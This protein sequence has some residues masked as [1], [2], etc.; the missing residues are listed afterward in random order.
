MLFSH[1]LFPVCDWILQLHH[2]VPVFVV[3]VLFQHHEVFLT[4]SSLH[5]RYK[6]RLDFVLKRL[7]DLLDQLAL[8]VEELDAEPDIGDVVL[9]S[10]HEVEAV[11]L[12]GLIL[13]L[14]PIGVGALGVVTAQEK[15]LGQLN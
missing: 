15:F 7:D 14:L 10:D 1:N 12:V 5:V 9:A 4:L 11:Q 13:L 6:H 3:T 2:V 8:H